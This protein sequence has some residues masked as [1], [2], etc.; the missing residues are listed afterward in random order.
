MK[1][2]PAIKR[3]EEDIA[4]AK[5]KIDKK[6]LLQKRTCLLLVLEHKRTCRDAECGVILYDLANLLR[7]NG[8]E[9]N[10]N[11]FDIFF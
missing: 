4:K 5:N 1:R 8:I 11:D 6:K 3:V 7:D 2:D 10:Y 9:L